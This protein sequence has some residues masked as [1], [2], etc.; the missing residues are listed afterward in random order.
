MF[1]FEPKPRDFCIL[2]HYAVCV[3]RFFI[4]KPFDFPVIFAHFHSFFSV[5]NAEISL[6]AIQGLTIII[7]SGKIVKRFN[8]IN[9]IIFTFFSEF[10]TR[11]NR[12]F[13]D[14]FRHSYLHFSQYF[15]L[16][17]FAF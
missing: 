11:R 4:G 5:L 7:N 2:I 16:F 10:S 12:C 17:R 14:V 3:A 8:G 9:E 1:I 13:F 15:V 6:V